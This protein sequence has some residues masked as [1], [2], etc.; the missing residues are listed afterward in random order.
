M[1]KAEPRETPSSQG[2]ND[3]IGPSGLQSPRTL[4]APSTLQGPGLWLLIAA[5]YLG[6]YLM[7]LDL[8]MLSTVIPTLT[9]EF[10]TVSD[11]SWYETAYIL[12]VPST[13]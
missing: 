7:A 4:E 12:A 11:I 2:A 8:T 5:L 6:I 1:E 10:G 3:L 9:N 13:N